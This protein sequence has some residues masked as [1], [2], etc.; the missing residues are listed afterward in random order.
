MAADG[1]KRVCSLLRAVPLRC[2]RADL[3][4]RRAF[5]TAGA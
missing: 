5:I 4:I 3:V 2:C 1:C